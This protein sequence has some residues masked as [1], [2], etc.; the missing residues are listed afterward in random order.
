[1]ALRCPPHPCE[2]EPA[3]HERRRPRSKAPPIHLVPR[4]YDV[5]SLEQIEYHTQ[6]THTEV[7]GFNE[8]FDSGCRASYSR[9]HILQK[10]PNRNTKYTFFKFA[11]KVQNKITSPF[12][13]L[14][15]DSRSN[16]RRQM[17]RG[18]YAMPPLHGIIP[19]PWRIS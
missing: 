1:M 7:A 13:Q 10:Y 17:H 3:G 12:Q 15:R 6:R 16:P 8:V 11:V 14:Q 18:E 5:K 9:S 2:V 19:F 4:N